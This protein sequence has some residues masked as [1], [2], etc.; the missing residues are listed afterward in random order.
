MACCEPS[1]VEMVM[2][3]Q[4]QSPTPNPGG[5]VTAVL[6]TAGLLAG[7]VTVPEEGLKVGPGLVQPGPTGRGTMDQLNVCA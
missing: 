5:R 3:Q 2:R 7:I 6:R 1:G 4:E